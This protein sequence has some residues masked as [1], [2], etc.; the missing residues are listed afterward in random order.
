MLRERGFEGGDGGIA[1]NN[2]YMG[3]LERQQQRAIIMS[4]F[5]S[6]SSLLFPLTHGHH[7]CCCPFFIIHQPHLHVNR[8]LSSSIS[9]TEE[10]DGD[11][12]VGDEQEFVSNWKTLSK[13]DQIS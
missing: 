1:R 8:L 2:L 11:V 10:D 12:E 9:S 5:S 13:G 6:S 7:H 3:C 4:S